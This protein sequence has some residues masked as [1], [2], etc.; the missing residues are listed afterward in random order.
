MQE[1]FRNDKKTLYLVSTPIGNLKDIT[2]R[3]VEV[4]SNVEVIFAEDTRTSMRLL[5]HYNIK[6]KMKSYHEHNK[7]EKENDVLWYLENGFD[8]ALISD[9]GT[10]GISDPGF[11]IA[12]KV[13]EKGFNVSSIPGATASMTAL[14]SSG[15]KMQPNLFLGFLPRKES[16]ITLF[17]N[18]YLTVD[19]TLIFYESPFRID[20][21]IN[22]LFEIL[23]DRRVVIARE[24]TK[25]YETF[26]R[27]TLKEAI[28][29]D[30]INK[31]EY[32]ILVEGFI[33]E[34]SNLSV[35]DLFVKYQKL[36]LDDMTNMKLIAKEL[37]ISKREV[38]DKIKTNK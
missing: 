24:L 8:V 35:I 13:I 25:I 32:V 30:F 11:E 3:A 2:Y 22:Y 29:M 31:G 6:T 4:L 37:G 23:G 14:V 9:A 28:K 18:K 36:G 10:P 34:E 26:I 21:T 33:Q 19:A 7:L 20:K 1:S 5:S 16:E 38:Y 27:T 15:L 17:L 12:N